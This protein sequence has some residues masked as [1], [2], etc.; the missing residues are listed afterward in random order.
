MNKYVRI[1]GTNFWIDDLEVGRSVTFDGIGYIK[2]SAIY[3]SSKNRY[4]VYVIFDFGA[5]HF[6]YKGIGAAID[7][8]QDLYDKYG[9]ISQLVG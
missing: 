1:G 5:N 6:L 8:L 2:A 9:V 4:F 3:R 7:K